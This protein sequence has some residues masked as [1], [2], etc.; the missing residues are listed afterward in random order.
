MSKR[1]LSTHRISSNPNM[2]VF[3]DTT[4]EKAKKQFRGA[5]APLACIEAVRASVH[6]PYHRGVEKE[7][8]LFLSLWAT[9][10]PQAQ[11]YAFFSEREAGKW[12]HPSGAKW[13]TEQPKHVRSAAVIG[14]LQSIRYFLLDY[15]SLSFFHCIIL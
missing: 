5:Q 6:L 2:E 7:R 9:G 13:Y 12:T 1:R 14:R 11:Q 15:C 8:Q 3:L 10:Q 4:V